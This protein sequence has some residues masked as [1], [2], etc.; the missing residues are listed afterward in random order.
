MR[1][2]EIIAE[3]GINHNGNM[4]F[5]S[6]M[7][8]RAKALGADVA[9]F[10][11]FNAERLVEEINPNLPE[12]NKK[13]VRQTELSKGDLV[14]LARTCKTYGIEFMSS[15]FDV[16]LVDWLE[17]INVERYKIP[18]FLSTNRKL[19]ET[20]LSTGKNV[21][22]SGDFR[23]PFLRHPTEPEFLPHPR[24]ALLYCVS[25]YPAKLQDIKLSASSFRK[26]KRYGVSGYDGFSDH[27][28]GLSAATYAM[29]LGAGIIEKHFTLDKS[30]DGPDHKCSISPIELK[31]LCRLRDDMETLRGF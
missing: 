27:T 22:V 5:A 10:Q 23:P 15:V 4:Y 19:C 16:D 18:K 1:K 20:V 31:Q 2:I 21:I 3:C 25:E 24:V 6:Q 13:W 17:D 7:I 8:R 30:L 9:K 26:D 14:F 11:L 12:Y 29:S 28:I